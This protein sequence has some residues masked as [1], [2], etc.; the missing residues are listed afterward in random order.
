MSINVKRMRKTMKDFS[1]ENQNQKNLG[2]GSKQK[3]SMTLVKA[4]FRPKTRINQTKKDT[5][6]WR[7][8][9]E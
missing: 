3:D 7:E 4:E 5:V 9:S 6:F 8:Q 1:L 2:G